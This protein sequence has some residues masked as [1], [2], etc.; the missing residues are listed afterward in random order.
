MVDEIAVRLNPDVLKWLR[1]ISGYSIEEVAEKLKIEVEKLELIEEGKLGPTFT[2]IRDLSKI[3]KVPVAAFF[4]PKPRE[5]PMPKDYRF[6]PGRESKFDKETLLVFRKVR[7][8]QKVAKELIENLG[9]TIEPHIERVSLKDKPEKIAEKYREEFGLTEE[10]Q[11][12]FKDASA[13]FKYL[14]QKIEELNIFVFQYGMPVKDAR[15]FTLTDD[16]PI[17]IT[18]NSKDLYKPRI[19][20]LMHEFGHVLLGESVVDIPNIAIPTTNIVERW[21]NEF[22]ASFLLPKDVAIKVFGE[23]RSSLTS[24]RTLGRLSGRY[25]VSKHMLLYTMFKLNYISLKEYEEFKKRFKP[26]SYRG[27][28]GPPPEVRIMSELGDK[29]LKLVVQNYKNNLISYSAALETIPSVKTRTFNKLLEQ[30][31]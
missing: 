27:S 19:F 25:K 23:N 14:R 4:L 18:V 15:G 16:F 30:V 6:I 13:M 12:E 11:A 20:T 26:S 29:Y 21:C 7:G 22:A 28:G 2:L 24:K 3:Y 10:L 1:E 9:Y 5:I 17:I 31:G 8:L